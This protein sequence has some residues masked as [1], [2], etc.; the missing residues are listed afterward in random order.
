MKKIIFSVLVLFAV[1]AL[2]ACSSTTPTQ[3]T[4]QT[5]FPASTQSLIDG[6]LSAT[7][8]PVY[9][10]ELRGTSTLTISAVPENAVNVVVLFTPTSGSIDD[11]FNSPKTIAK[12]L[13][14]QPQSMQ[15]AT[16]S[17][18]DGQY[19]LQIVAAGIGED[20]TLALVENTYQVK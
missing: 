17:L 3:T 5:Q 1:V 2:V 9:G 7:L 11:V 20:S 14:A 6:G 15:L 8:S 18:P 19:R 12:I 13:S 10:T 16:A 4:P